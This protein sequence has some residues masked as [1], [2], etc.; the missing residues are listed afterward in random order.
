[1]SEEYDGWA[2]KTYGK[3]HPKHFR[4]NKEDLIAQVES[5][6]SCLWEDIKKYDN[7]EIVKVKLVEVE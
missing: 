6:F 1:M 5:S 4:Q 2:F 7:N 3:I